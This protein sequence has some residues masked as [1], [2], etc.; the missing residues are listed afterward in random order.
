[1]RSGLETFD[2]G[3]RRRIRRLAHVPADQAIKPMLQI[4]DAR[5]GKLRVQASI[6]RDA[7]ELALSRA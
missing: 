7:R 2:Q 5:A 3:H 4:R 6:G 1:M